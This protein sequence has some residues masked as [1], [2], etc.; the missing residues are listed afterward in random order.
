MRE[1]KGIVWHHSATRDGISK[2][3]TAIRRYHTSYRIDGHIVDRLTY[4]G[5]KGRGE[6]KSF[7]RPWRDIGY[8]GGIEYVDGKLRFFWGRSLDWSGAHSG[9]GG[10]LDSL[11]YNR[12]YIGLCIVGNFDQVQPNSEQ[13][14]F[15]V[16]ISSLLCNIYQ[17]DYENVIGHR[18][19]YDRLEMARW[20][21]CPGKFFDMDLIRSRL[22]S[23]S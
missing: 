5:R 12:R 23:R 16:T 17:M 19:V 20:K 22:K 10:L 1:W 3:W 7:Q 4:I 15:C 13:I 2:N 21:S 9:I 11:E 6:G 8:H 18:E 14:D